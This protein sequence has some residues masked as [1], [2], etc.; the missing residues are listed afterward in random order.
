MHSIFFVRGPYERP[1]AGYGQR[2]QLCGPLY[3]EYIV[4]QF[5][6][7]EAQR[8]DWFR[9]HQDDIST[10][11]LLATLPFYEHLYR[12][13]ARFRAELYT[14]V[15]DAVDRGDVDVDRIGRRVILPGSFTY[16]RPTRCT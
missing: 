6:R 9:L 12:E 3:E 15:M 14:G 8:L 13:P 2:G 7:M 1:L 11:L 16:A 5:C 10:G 4:T